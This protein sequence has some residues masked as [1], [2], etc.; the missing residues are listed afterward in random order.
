MKRSAAI[1]GFL[2]CC[3]PL[4]TGADWREFRGPGHRSIAEKQTVPTVWDEAS[5]IAWKQNLPGRAVSSPIVVGGRVI[6]TSASGV[7]SERLHVFA[8]DAGSGKQLWHRQ[9]WATGR[10]QCHPFSSIA[11]PTPAS[12]GKQIYA[13]FAS[14]DLICLDLDGNLKWLRG[15]TH[16]YP[17]AANDVGMSSSPCVIGDTVIVQVE[18]L[19]HSFAAG[20]DTATGVERWKI[21][22]PA[23]M[24]YVS[25]TLVGGS[26]GDK[27]PHILLQS[28]TLLSAHDPRTGKQLW[29]YVSEFRSI[30]SPLAVDGILYARA[31][32]GIT[33]ISR[34]SSTAESEVLWS[35]P[36]L[37]PTS[38]SPLVYRGRIYGLN[39]TGVLTCADIAD[40]TV[41]WQLRLKGPFWATPVVVGNLLYCINH[42][43]LTQVVELGKKGKIIA[44]NQLSDKVYGSPAIAN[45]ALYIRSEHALW[46]IQ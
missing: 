4:T 10:T 35:Q 24:N 12:D 29:S 42:D 13:F 30:V 41:Q 6:T 44:R 38:S 8:L 45:N 9:F 25:P 17:T 22:R 16:D 32:Q 18:N 3:V 46:M 14:N 27:A 26:G 40:G 11:A 19:V 7:R 1:I 33:A 39:R 34:K 36:K 2:L 23:R 43:G 31:D 5:G 28:P 15:L 37:S 21:Q 20:I